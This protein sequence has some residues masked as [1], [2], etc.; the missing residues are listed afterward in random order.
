MWLD[1]LEVDLFLILNLFISLERIRAASGKSPF[2][3]RNQQARDELLERTF[4]K[5]T[6]WFAPSKPLF[7]FNA[8]AH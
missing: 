4:R 5:S 3:R 6:M 8:H 7:V 1:L 2:Q